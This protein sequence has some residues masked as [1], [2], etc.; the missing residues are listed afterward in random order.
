MGLLSIPIL[1][2]ALALLLAGFA[3]WVFWPRGGLYARWQ[4]RRRGNLR[5][6][7]EDAL[8]HIHGC[9]MA[10]RP[11]TLEGLAGSLLCSTG[12]AARILGELESRGLVAHSD[13]GYQL[14]V[15]GRESALHIVRAHRLWERYLAE[16]TGYHEIEWHERADQREHH[17]SKDQLQVLSARLGHPTHDPHGDP[18]PTAEGDWSEPQGIPLAQADPEANYR[19]VHIEDEP[20]TIYAQL[21]AEGVHLGQV[22][23][24]ME[25]SPRR[26]RF[27]SEG[28]EHALAP[29]LAENLTVRRMRDQQ[30]IRRE[31]EERLSHL[32]VGEMAKVVALSPACRGPERR[33]LLDLGLVSGTEIKAELVSP[34]GDPK[35][36][37]IRGAVIALRQEQADQVRVIRDGS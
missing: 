12:Q 31:H 23:R 15:R 18:I 34:S 32:N 7:Q 27:W 16:E 3:A 37:R 21:L 8:K 26:I 4:R 25:R 36:Y 9:Q 22:L 33:R 13:K 24:V 30:V 35:A 28:K 20:E 2:L 10:G 19:I 6:L 5:V 11:L 17:L 1:M 14:T 29:L